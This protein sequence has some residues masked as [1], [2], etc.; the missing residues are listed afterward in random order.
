MDRKK[1]CYER[2]LRLLARREHSA[3]ELT[4]KLAARGFKRDQVDSA[5]AR[6]Q[7]EGYQSDERFAEVLV[8]SRISRREGPLKI[9]ARLFDKGINDQLIDKYLPKDED[10]WVRQAAELDGLLCRRERALENAIDDRELFARRARHLKNKGYG[11]AVISRVL[12]ERGFRGR[13]IKN[14]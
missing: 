14:E 2:A 13:S 4:F 6:V 8:R 10:I 9:R 7:C 11:S 12:N 5:V 1:E 3:R